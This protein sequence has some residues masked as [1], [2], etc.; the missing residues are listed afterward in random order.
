MVRS[1]L[2][3]SNKTSLVAIGFSVVLAAMLVYLTIGGIVVNAHED[4]DEYEDEREYGW[5]FSCQDRVNGCT[6][7]GL[8][9]HTEM[10]PSAGV[11]FIAHYSE[12]GNV[13]ARKVQFNE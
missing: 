10:G 9:Y 7:G 8:L 3:E 1:V 12:T 6:E 2:T 11:Y 4:E 5:V 13:Y